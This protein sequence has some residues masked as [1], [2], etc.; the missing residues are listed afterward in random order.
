MMRLGD[1]LVSL[2]VVALAVI[3]LSGQTL[4]GSALAQTESAAADEQVDVAA[5]ADASSADTTARTFFEFGRIQSRGDWVAPVLVS[6]VLVGFVVWLY[7]RDAVEQ[8][9]ALRMLLTTLRAAVIVALVVIWLEPQ[10]RTER[11]VTTPSRVLLVC[12]T[13]LSMGLVDEQFPSAPAGPPRSDQV[14]RA[15]KESE[16]IERLRATH[17][18]VVAGFDQSLS[19]VA[20]LPKLTAAPDDGAAPPPPTSDAAPADAK[21]ASPANVDWAAALAPR[22]AET[23]LGQSLRDLLYDERAN[24]LSGVAV[25]SDGGQNAG[26]GIGPATALAHEL[27][28]PVHAVGVG[29]DRQPTNVRV[30]DLVAPSRAFPGDSYTVTGYIQAQGLGGRTV[31]VELY[32][33][34]QTSD[35]AAANPAD[36]GA[37]AGAQQVTLGADGEVVPVKFELTPAEPG[38]ETLRL[39]IAAPPDDSNPNDNE[40]QADLEIVSHKTRVLLLASGPTREYCFLHTQLYRDHN[41]VVDILLQTAQPGISQEANAILEEFPTTREE[42]DAYDCIVAFDPDWQQFDRQQIELLERWVGEQAGGLIVVPGPVFG[43]SWT[44]EQSLA[45]LRDLYPV[46][47]AHRFAILDGTRYQSAEPWALD[48]TREGL[49]ADFLWLG[50]SAT[51]SSAAWSSF[52]GVYGYMTVHGPKPGATVYARFSDPRTAVGGQQPP[53]LVGHFYGSGR[54]FY[55]GSGEMWRLRSIDPAYFEEVYTKLIRHV[56]QGRLL[57][58]S[59]RGVLLVERDRYLVGQTVAVRAQLTNPQLEPLVADSVTLDVGPADQA[60]F[61]VKLLPDPTRAGAFAGEFVV[62]SEGACRLE[63]LVPDSADERIT[64]RVQVRVPDLERE[65]PQRNDVLLGELTRETGGTYYIGLPAALGSA[66][67]PP[68]WDVL[69]NRSRTLTVSDIPRPIWDNAYTMF[70]LCGC[71]SLEWLVRRLR[72]LA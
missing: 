54:V 51:S 34:R 22:G 68:L 27:G 8:S 1:R 30:S 23:R 32:S 15:L 40:Q 63:L 46:E 10:W 13:S 24:P 52:P 18:V 26:V 20:T 56:S 58:G 31:G 72:K 65:S 42:L 19:A 2:A 47:F 29:S 59:S 53:F 69:P 70:F 21:I 3:W 50:D 11:D 66:K 25:L 48:F 71:L 64:K 5:V 57:R 55:L 61:Q 35:G 43:Q 9:F 44:D 33:R 4:V 38:R 36:L 7:R 45:K 16:L 17:D 49:E 39:R 37:L 60:N 41:M 6:L 28:I 14:I 12:D 67:Q 62:R